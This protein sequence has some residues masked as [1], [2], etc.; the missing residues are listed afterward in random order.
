MKNQ[1]LK[2]KIAV[3]AGAFGGIG[4]ELC[5]M[6]ADRNAVLILAVRNT[7]SARNN[8]FEL[9]TRNPH[10]FLIENDY[11]KKESWERLAEAVI[12]KFGRIDY[13]INC[14]GIIN[15]KKFDE[16][17]YE[18]IFNYIQ[19]NFLST[20]YGFKTFLPQMKKQ[21]SGHFI[22]VGSLGGIIPMPYETM[23]SATKFA[24]RG[25]IISLSEELK[26]CGINVS[27]ISP[28][29]VKTKLLDKEAID[30]NST[31]AFVSKPLVPEYVAAEILKLMYKPKTEIILPKLL[32]KISLFVSERSA[33]FTFL[34]PILNLIGQ[35]RLK[36]YRR[37]NILK[38]FSSKTG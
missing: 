4:Y 1:S 19:T 5:D 9:K 12:K 23:Y 18:E 24:L 20:V 25:F 14:I 7:G 6:L 26:E 3:V 35:Y 29:P 2:G 15:P 36:K 31:L 8:F 30:S 33:L 17:S 11:T 38:S 10:S 28:G 21:N 37:D 34:Y 16:L 27:L 32:N 13:L 22:T